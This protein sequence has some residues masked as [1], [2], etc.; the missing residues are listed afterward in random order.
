M[1][2]GVKKNVMECISIFYWPYD[3]LISFTMGE[4]KK[5]LYLP[6]KTIN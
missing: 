2:K 4:I 1:K 6:G 3:I 5:K